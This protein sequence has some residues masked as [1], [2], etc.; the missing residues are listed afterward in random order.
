MHF[1]GAFPENDFDI[2]LFG[3]IAAQ[4]T[5]RN[6]YHAIAVQR[7]DDFDRVARRTA[8]VCFCADISIGIDIGDNGYARILLAQPADIFAGNGGGQ[9]AARL[10]VGQQHRLV[11]TQD[12]GRFG[13]EPDTAHDD[14][15]RIDFRAALSQC[16]RVAG[17]ISD[18]I[19]HF[20]CLVVVRQHDGVAFTLEFIDGR[21]QRGV[22]RPLDIRHDMFKAF[23]NRPGLFL[24][25]GREFE[26]QLIV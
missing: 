6:K 16:Q 15:I 11:R 4:V 1:T 19:E 9:R 10:H 21:D 25:F 17:D 24:D 5:I 3:D 2:G 18:A 22:N 20:G 14:D 7:F 23:E 8:D 26:G 12:F 13:H